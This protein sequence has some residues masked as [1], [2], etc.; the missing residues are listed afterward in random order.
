MSTK[1]KKRAFITGIAGFAGS[2]L[3]EQL[4]ASGY[5]V[6]G[7]VAPGEPTGNLAAI[8]GK[9]KLDRLDIRSAKKCHE[10]L[11]KAKPT[12]IF[13]LA[14]FASVGRSFEQ[15]ADVY[16]INIE[17]TL[18]ILKASLG[19]AGLKRFLFVSSPD[20]YG[21]VSPAGRTLTETDPLTPVS[22]YGISKA[23][24]E[25]ISLSF[26]GRHGLPVVVARAFNHTGPR[27]NPDFVIPSF[28]RQIAAIEAG[29]TRPV[30]KVGNLSA[31]RDL[32]DVRDIVRGYQLL[33]E[34]GRPGEVYQLCR[35]RAV[36]IDSLLSRMLGLSKRPI[37]I[38]ID[39]AKLRPIDIPVLRGAFDKARQEVGFEHRYTLK[40]TLVDTLN[41][42][43]DI[44]NK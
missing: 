25:R 3:A 11:A 8:K 23:A 42:W 41:Y 20:C 28:A 1:S 12:S 14:A 6:H 40:T 13:H 19:L 30:I 7:S 27:Q 18:N 39:P 5:Q 24:A 35:G 32:S 17:G 43:R 4:I 15:E 2:W 31:R 37:K 9:L 38:E 29:K 36:S 21:P 26:F 16:R 44:L 33:V 34:C 10:V 22:P